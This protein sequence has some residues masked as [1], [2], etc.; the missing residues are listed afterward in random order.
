MA[1]G[2]IEKPES[3][4]SAQ[5]RDLMLAYAAS[6][7]AGYVCGFLTRTEGLVLATVFM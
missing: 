3:A 1:F 7:F 2:S 4:C 6:T 5:G